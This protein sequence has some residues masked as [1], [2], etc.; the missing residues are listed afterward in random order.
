MK[1][2]FDVLSAPL[3][4]RWGQDR[5]GGLAQNRRSALNPTSMRES[6]GTAPAAI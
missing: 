3:G 2:G 6:V 4:S 5:G 1:R